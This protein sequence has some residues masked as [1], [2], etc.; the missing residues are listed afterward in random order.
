MNFKF[1]PTLRR[2]LHLAAVLAFTSCATSKVTTSNFSNIKLGTWSL[3]QELK[4]EGVILIPQWHL[5]SSISA[6]TDAKIAQEVNQ[7]AIFTQL[8]TW[9][10]AHTIDAILAEGC[11]GAIDAQT[12]QKFNGWSINDLKGELSKQNSIDAILAPIAFKVRVKYPNDIQVV[13]ADN[14]SL[15][16]KNQLALSNLRGFS[17]FKFRIEQSTL[18]QSDHQTFLN[19][20]REALSLAKNSPEKIVIESLNSEVKKSLADFDLAIH[21]RN[22]S[23][24]SKSRSIHG[25]KVIVIGAVHLK[26]LQLQLSQS[27]IA[28]SVWTPV[29]IDA[30][31]TQLLEQLKSKLKLP[32]GGS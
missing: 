32:E 9:I 22:E 28:F 21:Q 26:D 18:S 20:S 23:F 4:G 30:K 19:A 17:G 16:Q 14:K 7:R 29:G 5:A 31:D 3:T 12:D 1:Y 8:S 24:I 13:C 15:I 25:I 10:E 6:K 27:N 11:E 2:A